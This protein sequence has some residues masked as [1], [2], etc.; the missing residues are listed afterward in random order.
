MH[1]KPRDQEQTMRKPKTA[2]DRLGAF[3]DGISAMIITIMAPELK[4][5]DRMTF[6]ALLPLW[7]ILICYARL[8]YRT[9]EAPGARR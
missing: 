2:P 6:S 9:P 8:P 1:R 5:P 7:L 3:S 4:A